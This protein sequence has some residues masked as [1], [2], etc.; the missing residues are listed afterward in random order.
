[1]RALVVHPGTQH[2]FRLAVELHRLSSLLGLHTGFAVASGGALQQICNA[3]PLYWTKRVANRRVDDLSHGLVHLQPVLELAALARIRGSSTDQRVLHWRNERFQRSIPLRDLQKAD[4][5]IGFDTSSWILAQRCREIGKPLVMVQTIGHPD[6]KKTIREELMK[7]FPAWVEADEPRL[8][9]VRKAEQQE[10]EGATLIVANSQFTKDTLVEN[11]VPSSK[12]RVIPAGVDCDQFSAGSFSSGRSLRF[13]FAG[14][15]NARKGVPLLLEAWHQLRPLNAELWLVGRASDQVKSLLP[16][17]PGLSY[18]GA[19]PQAELPSILRQCDVFVFPSYFEGF[20]RVILQAMACGLPV[21]TTHSSGA[22]TDFFGD[23]GAGWI[24]PRGSTD[25]L[26]RAMKYCIAHQEDLRIAGR[27]AREIAE[28]FDW[29]TYG[30]NWL[31]ILEEA[32]RLISKPASTLS[33][34]H[35]DHDLHGRP[36]VPSASSSRSLKVGRVLL[37]HPGTQYSARLASQLQRH[38]VLHEFHTSLA[39]SEDSRLA[40]IVG[41]LPSNWQERL[42]NRR[43]SGVPRDLLFTKPLYELAALA[44]LQFGKDEQKV[45]FRRNAAFQRSL[46]DATINS[47]DI[48]IGFDTS[49]WI[50]SGRARNHGK[51]FVLDQSIGH[52]CSFAAVAGRLKKDFPEWIKNIPVKT[53]EELSREAQEHAAATFIVVP[54]GFVARTLIENGVDREKIRINPFGTDLLYFKPAA[55]APPLNPFRFVFAGSLQARKGLPLLL[56]AWKTLPAGNQ[57]ELWIAGSGEIPASVRPT[58]AASIHFLGRLPQERL[59]EVFRQSH[60]LV[61]PSYFEGLAQVQ[62]E[63]ATCGLPVIGTESSGC[64]EIVR[65]EDTGFVLPTG[66]LDALRN[67]LLR[68]IVEPELALRMRERLLVERS[69]LSWDAYGDRW[70]NLIHEF[71]GAGSGGRGAGSGEQGAGSGEQGGGSGERGAGSGERG[72]GSGEQDLNHDRDTMNRNSFL[73]PNS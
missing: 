47:S 61:F 60:V 40:S 51:I 66:N 17:L 57:A 25:D 3:L 14:L 22:G 15:I 49:S 68:F 58:L 59:A 7:R 56:E 28:K 10:H 69:N 9:I 20:A 8:S 24:I 11:G 50:I 41:F 6:S 2:S 70:L 54:S 26:I 63:A 18:L 62:I 44:A 32:S 39:F 16:K 30:K 19:V 72:A 31:P 65:N 64:E 43:L 12:I 38:G 45:L 48:V 71:R 36:C 42:A 27:A 4:V 29:A 52:P 33:Q 37:V 21:I 35:L 1:M 46:S 5:V 73:T 53:D 55:L 23:T 34:R 13:V 67:A